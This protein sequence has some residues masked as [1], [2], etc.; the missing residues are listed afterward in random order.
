VLTLLKVA[1]TGTLA[2]G[3]S[4]VCKFFKEL[5]ADMVSADQIVH[6]LLAGDPIIKRKV[7]ELLGKEVEI[8]G[9]LDRRKIAGKVFDDLKLL[10]GLEAIIHPVV[11]REIESRC[12]Q[13]MENGKVPLFVAEIPLLFEGESKAFDCTIAVL[14]KEKSCRSRFVNLSGASDLEFNQRIRRQLS[15]AEKANRADRV[16]Q[17]NGTLQNLQEETKKI[18]NQLTNL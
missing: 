5:G 17:N 7:V 15:Q 6:Q 16:I 4:S 9:R 2:S 11:Y 12:Q 3:K 10:H 18:F 14:S 1:V 8:N 13:S